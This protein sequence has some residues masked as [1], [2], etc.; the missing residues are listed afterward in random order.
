MSD[1]EVSDQTKLEQEAGRKQLAINAANF[2]RAIKLREEEAAP[3]D[4]AAA[5]KAA[6]DAAVAQAIEKKGKDR[7][8]A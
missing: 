7:G 3:K 5:D 8:R 1:Y 6:A 2:D 4:A